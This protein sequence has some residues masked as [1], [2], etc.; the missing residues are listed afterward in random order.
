MIERDAPRD[1]VAPRFARREFH[2]VVALQ[3]FD[4]FGFDQG[5]FEVWFRLEE[6]SLAQGVAV[7]FQPHSGDGEDLRHRNAWARSPWGRC[8]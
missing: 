3:R 8:R 7:A 4:G 2:V 1:Q 6:S 5:Q